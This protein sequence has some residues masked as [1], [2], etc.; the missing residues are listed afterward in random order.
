M[1]DS[2]EVLE[3]IKNDPKLLRIP[4]IVLTS[5]RADIDILKTYEL[6]ANG[7]VV[8]PVTFEWLQEI[9]ASIETFWFTVVVLATDAAAEQAADAA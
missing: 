7:Y 1:A 9:V 8:K 6:R 4:V 2:P 5:S 3:A